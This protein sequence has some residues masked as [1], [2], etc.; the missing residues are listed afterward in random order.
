MLCLLL[1]LCVKKLFKKCIEWLMRIYLF[2]K[3]CIFARKRFYA[4]NFVQ[5][6]QIGVE[7]VGKIWNH[8]HRLA[9]CASAEQVCDFIVHIGQ[10]DFP[11]VESD[12]MTGT[13]LLKAFDVYSQIFLFPQIN[14]NVI[15]LGVMKSKW[16]NLYS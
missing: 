1:N 13:S 2:N 9:T 7:S 3:I 4:F 6:R 10:I 8:R 5:K 16:I 12:R 11:A 14:Y 15:S